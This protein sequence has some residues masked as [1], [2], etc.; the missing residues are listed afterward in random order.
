MSV[1]VAACSAALSGALVLA[2]IGSAAAVGDRGLPATSSRTA[3]PAADVLLAVPVTPA[4]PVD[5]PRPVGPTVTS[6]AATAA[7]PDDPG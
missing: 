3:R 1:P 5:G 2:M 6:A 7:R 4:A